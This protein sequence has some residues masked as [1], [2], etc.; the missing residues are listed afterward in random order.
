M[1]DKRNKPVIPE[2]D[3]PVPVPPRIPS[4][5]QADVNGVQLKTFHIGSLDLGKAVQGAGGKFND[6]SRDN[7]AMDVV[8]IEQSIHSVAMNL[9]SLDPSKPGGVQVMHHVI[10]WVW[11]QPKRLPAD[12]KVLLLKV[13]RLCNSYGK[14]TWPSASKQTPAEA[15]DEFFKSIFDDIEAVVEANDKVWKW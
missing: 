14:G 12:V 3:P 11:H 8:C 6:W 2:P 1:N 9:P 10:L 15:K 13:Q 4:D 5:V 7:L